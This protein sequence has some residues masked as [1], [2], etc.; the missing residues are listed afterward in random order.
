AARGLKRLF[1]GRP[2]CACAQQHFPERRARR[3][4]GDGG[5]QRL[6][7]IHAAQSGRR[8]GFSHFRQ[9]AFGR[10]CDVVVER[11]RLDTVASRENWFHFSI[12]PTA[13]HADGVRK[14]RT[15]AAPCRK[16]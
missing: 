6:R 11:Q 12:V 10:S 13:S 14:R 2:A 9:R 7:K 8:D 1:D 15:A 4:C 5:T 3:I 16:V